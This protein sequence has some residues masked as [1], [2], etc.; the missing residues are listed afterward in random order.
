MSLKPRTFRRVVLL[1]SL[2]GLLF[3]GG[4]GYFVF[5][6]WQNQRQ[7]NSMLD[8]GMNA[9]ESGNYVTAHTLIGRYLGRTDNPDPEIV[10]AYA[11]AR[12]KVQASDGGHIRV[13]ILS[14][15][16]YLDAVPSDVEVAREL[17]P[18]FNVAGMW[19]EAKA[20]AQRLR[21]TYNDDSIGVL[22]ELRR[23]MS[24]L[25]ENPQETDEIYQ[26]CIAH[27]DA[28]F[29]DYFQYTD[30][31]DKQGR[32]DEA[33]SLIADALEKNPNDPELL[34]CSVFL[35]FLDVQRL[36]ASG[37]IERRLGELSIELAHALGLEPQTGEWVESPD[38]LSDQ[39]SMASSRLFNEMG[40][41]DL[42]LA[43]RVK[44]ALTIR[45]TD[46]LIWAARR[47]Y[48]ADDV[49]TL[50]QLEFLNN[51][52]D[53][54]SDVLG[55]QAL[56]HRDDEDTEV[57]KSK[58][59]ALSALKLDFQ[60]RTWIG[61]L[62]AMKLIDDA[63][64]V[65]ARAALTKAITLNPNEPTFHLVMGDIHAS[66]GLIKPAMEE[67]EQSFKFANADGRI[68]WT[69]PLI[70]IVDAY[71]KA[72]RLSEVSDVLEL[73]ARVAPNDPIIQAVR[74]NSISQLAVRG[75]LNAQST[76]EILNNYENQSSSFTQERLSS[77]APIIANLYAINDQPDQAR[78][79]L[80]AALNTSPSPQLL[81]EMMQVDHAYNLG[82][83]KS[84]GI[85]TRE[86]VR[87]TPQAALAFA[88]VANSRDQQF[89]EALEVLDEG[90]A[91]ASE[92]E[93]YDWKLARAKYLDVFLD[94]KEDPRSRQAWDELRRLYPN[95][96]ELLYLVAESKAFR[97]D[98]AAVNA[99]IAQFVEN[100]STAGQTLPSR[101]R[102]AQASSIIAQGVTKTNRQQ[103]VEIAR[104]VVASE[105]KNIAARKLLADLLSLS[106]PPGLD[107][108]QTFSRDIPGAVSQYVSIAR[109]INGKASQGYLLKA[110]QLS[111][112]IKD[113][114]NAKSYLTEAAA[115]YPN[116]F[117]FLPQV[118]WELSQINEHRQAFEIYSKLKRI[119]PDP[120]AQIDASLEMVHFY[121]LQG[122]LTQTHSLLNELAQEE[123]LS[124]KQLYQLVS[125]CERAGFAPNGF[126][127]VDELARSGEQFLLNPI[128]AKMVYA[129]YTNQFISKEVGEAAFIEV[130]ALDPTQ[131]E[132]WKI[133]IYQ[134]FD[135]GRTEEA[136]ELSA[137][138]RVHLPQSK[139]IQNISDFV[140]GNINSASE[141]IAQGAGKNDDDAVDAA[142]RVDEYMQ[143]K[144]SIPD[145]VQTQASANILLDL[146]KDY[147][148]NLPVQR[149]A[150]EELA[151]N[152]VDPRLLVSFAEAAVKKYPSDLKLLKIAAIIYLTSQ[153]F[154]MALDAGQTWK[155]LIGS[156]PSESSLFVAKALIQLGRFSQA[157]QEL[158]PYYAEALNA[159]EN[160]MNLDVLFFSAYAQLRSGVPSAQVSA[161]LEPLLSSNELVR[162]SV[163]MNLA[164]EGVLTIEQGAEWLDLVSNYITEQERESLARAWVQL[165]EQRGVWV[166]QYAQRSI[167]LLSPI[168]SQDPQNPDSLGLL[169]QAYAAKARSQTDEQSRVR[170]LATAIELMERANGINPKNFAYLL[171]AAHYASES[172]DWASAESKYRRL[173]KQDIGLG[174]VSVTIHN[175][176][177]MTIERQT[178]DETRLE[179]ALQFAT[180]ATSSTDDPSFWGTRGWVELALNQLEVAQSS[181]QRVVTLN[182]K[183]M[184]GWVGLAIVQH[185][186]GP[187]HQPDAAKSFAEVLKLHRIQPMDDELFNRLK[188]GGS[189]AWESQLNQ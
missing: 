97:S 71:S 121:L 23:A 143:L 26:L 187:D 110:A 75:E 98:L 125:A 81:L 78:A 67:W 80:K 44:S 10:L 77:V 185:Q 96:I 139:L 3:L 49:S 90:V 31:L 118:A 120:K 21:T 48:W 119:S 176:L 101:L 186:L 183:S 169:S 147:P 29:Q 134:V 114:I 159:S 41:P 155:S 13:A 106:P 161:R 133:L 179:E 99:V 6:P 63:K 171:H 4:F 184:E 141:F 157:A 150:L 32:S 127:S 83:A 175:N 36:S 22:R 180:V 28:Q 12:L 129:Q 116:D 117:N 92:S 11:R 8:D 148:E 108:E 124:F 43:V 178:R 15:R 87:A 122:Q 14:F 62:D 17:L 57:F 166:S 181:F 38:F 174:W 55:Y 7:L 39:L 5:R 109:Q 158:E 53:E 145:G 34:T 153:N 105:Q 9:Y 42:S 189:S 85:N 70:R 112:E 163:W 151:F 154:E 102:I 64:P 131:E 104:S 162:T 137:Q 74:P 172:N 69:T 76:Q 95:T 61:L 144:A 24:Q 103:A 60:A 50:D 146:L 135:Q 66:L 152:G 113:R 149:F 54:I 30:R 107:E 19:I 58:S 93:K 25:Q 136:K 84:E 115:L 132:V 94:P 173:L 91:N 1:G 126:T 2:V 18:I 140:A 164:V 82:L 20:L 46:S 128:D 59:T 86:L 56:A 33:Q 111:I 182:P 40:R 177:A 165:M 188:S 51:D 130:L 65:D 72:N 160:M 47:L 16:R 45:D 170:E 167:D 35:D 138:A 73:I 52:G 142:R 88:V 168:V 68:P 89:E 156:D 100:T 79:V 123:S 27:P 37:D